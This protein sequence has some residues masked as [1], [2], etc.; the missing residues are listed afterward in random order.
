M[1]THDK[2]NRLIT[3]TG[4]VAFNVT[5]A[6]GAFDVTPQADYLQHLEPMTFLVLGAAEY[7]ALAM[8]MEHAPQ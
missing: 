6:N 1:L 7:W 3:S 5:Y 4:E 8:V 2:Y